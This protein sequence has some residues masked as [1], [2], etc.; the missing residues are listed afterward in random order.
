M[1]KKI[2]ILGLICVSLLTFNVNSVK[3]DTVDSS[4][5]IED[6]DDIT[7]R[8]NYINRMTVN[9]GNCTVTAKKSI[10]NVTITATLEKKVNGQWKYISSK[11]ASGKSRCTISYSAG[12]GHRVRFTAN[13]NGEILTQY[14]YF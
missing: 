10:Y 2:M 1:K 5:S 9:R 13:V 7:P 4:I 11:S 12:A 8:Y 6:T 3:A 14:G